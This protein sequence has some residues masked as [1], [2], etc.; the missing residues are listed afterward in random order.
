MLRGN[1]LSTDEPKISIIIPVYNVAQYL[2][3]CLDSCVNQTMKDIEIVMV[4]DCSPDKD[5]RKI[6]DIY[7]NRY[8]NKV[9]CFYHGMNKRQGGARNTSIRNARGEY[10]LFVDSDDYIA[11]TMC[12]D[13]YEKAVSDNCDIVWCDY[14]EF[15][16]N[17][18]KTVKIWLFIRM[19]GKKIA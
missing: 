1:G 6:M 4:N 17:G 8:P 7:V 5:D 2:R 16:E 10:L 14:Y 15:N 9:R 13:M 12:Q 19:C 18:T 3:R 11:E